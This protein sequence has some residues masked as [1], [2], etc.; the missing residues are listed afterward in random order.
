[1]SGSSSPG[2]T[3]PAAEFLARAGA[4]SVKISR[5]RRWQSRALLLIGVVVTVV[6][7]FHLTQSVQREHEAEFLRTVEG[8]HSA[9]ERRLAIY[10]EA[11]QGLRGFLEHADVITR[12]EFHRYVDHLDLELRHPGIQSIDF[13]R[14]LRDAG[15]D[16]FE[17]SVRND[18]VS[19]LGSFDD[20]TI[21]PPGRRDEYHV[22]EF[23]EPIQTNRSMIGTDISLHPARLAAILRARDSGRATA[24]APF[25]LL[26]D[27]EPQPAFRLVMPVYRTDG[28]Q[29]TLDQRR[30]NYVGAISLV[31]RVA[32][33]IQTLLDNLDLTALRLR[34]HYVGAKDDVDADD[35]ELLFDTD[36]D[37][38]IRSSVLSRSL[39]MA[40]GEQRW[41]ISVSAWA[42]FHTYDIS[43]LVPWAILI[44]GLM[45]SLLLFRVVAAMGRIEVISGELRDSE[46]HFARLAE[47]TKE[48]VILH[49]NGKIIDI[50]TA[51]CIL[52]GY[53]REDLTG[54]D[55]SRLVDPVS[56]EILRTQIADASDQSYEAL[57]RRRDGSTFLAEVL[58][59]D[60][61]FRGEAMRV[62][63]VRDVT[64]RK[65]EE[66]E[67]LRAKEQAEAAN[68]SKSEFLANMSHEIRTP[69][70]AILG[71]GY[72]LDL[73]EPT[74]KQHDYIE[75]I[76]SSAQSLLGILNDIL[77]YSKVE[78]GKMELERVDFRL[79]KIMEN[80]ATIMSINAKEKDIEV[81]FSVESSVPL[82]LIGD[83][84]RLQQVLINLTGNAVKFTQQG[85]VV[86]R[87][88][89]VGLGSSE[90]GLRFSVSDTGIG[91]TR[92][93][94][95]RL[96]QPFSQGDASTTRR[97]GGTGLGLAICSRLVALMGGAIAVDSVAGQ[98]STFSFTARFERGLASVSESVF[99]V[100][101]LR[102]L[103]I[104]VVDD[105][106]TAREILAET[107]CAMGWRA[108]VA[109]SGPAALVAL[110]QM[111]HEGHPFDVVFMDWKMPGM[112][113]I[114]TTRH[115]KEH[116]TGTAPPIVIMVTAYGREQI[117]DRTADLG[118]EGV[119]VKPVTSSALFNA[120]VNAWGRRNAGAKPGIVRARKI[121]ARATLGGTR[122][123]LVEDNAINQQVAREIL[124]RAGAEVIVADDGLE[125]LRYLDTE[126]GVAL[127][128]VLMDV[129][130]PGMDGYETT[131]AIRS[132][133]AFGALPI[134]AMTANA[135]VGDREKCLEA[136]MNDHVPKPL[137]VLKL[138]TV[139]GNWVKPHPPAASVAPA[140]PA[141]SAEHTRVEVDGIVLPTDLR[142]L[143]LPEALARLG[144]NSRLL[145]KLLIQFAKDYGDAAEQISALLADGDTVSAE[146][147]AHSIKGVAG[148]LA[149]AALAQAAHTLGEA[150]R[151]QDQAAF[152]GLLAVFDWELAQ[153]VA[154]C[155]RIAAITQQAGDKATTAARTKAGH[156]EPASVNLERCLAVIDALIPLLRTRNAR[157]EE[158]FETLRGLLATTPYAP[159]LSRIEA[160]L[161]QFQFLPAMIILEALRAQI[162][163]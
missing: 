52:Y 74:A 152:P 130:M 137:D 158:V 113:G 97:Y 46:H 43:T 119:L 106:P 157:A 99:P 39:P 65:R 76:S 23:S 154:S 123:L 133:P 90:I 17:R 60:V 101:E 151:S 11:L 100:E 139:L 156:G 21:R 148:N 88:E 58:G 111:A 147:L 108:A 136:G 18:Y 131:R 56:L 91:M 64:Q 22:I 161:D 66:E 98:G 13:V 50:N 110:E 7:W 105:N 112:D 142:G 94:C 51:F 61:V 96:F 3:G 72:L 95:T 155:T 53:S 89:P 71:L 82:N 141:V 84:L 109:R 12:D 124:E 4:S 32:D 114:E 14:L 40:V 42:N 68:K 10:M 57:M 115:I 121:E 159:E 145:C 55:Y 153:V 19:G 120:V 104:L 30:A 144:D 59:R 2:S 28:V 146:R 70:N 34:I 149:A 150:I 6:T 35:Q 102:D 24:S 85:E 125:A 48:G 92:E 16:D 80:L 37:Q 44:G 63:A 107:V 128:A 31:F 69:M 1:M 9:I 118:L 54:T 122:L 25:G 5:T 75:K 86:V 41:I 36:P 62:A 127:D 47:L 27:R 162:T 138:L 29:T 103:R 126:G 160:A 73:T 134:I 26:T 15:R 33:L 163:A 77:D 78:A 67:L 81:L 143:N 140:V 93:Q 132:R 45:I 49:A 79:D 20:F 8:I 83:P 87:V 135:M 129:Q 38:E 117:L 116:C